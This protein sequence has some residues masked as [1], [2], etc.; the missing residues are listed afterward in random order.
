[1]K[2]KGYAWIYLAG[3]VFLA[4]LLSVVP[5]PPEVLA[6]P[7]RKLGAAQDSVVQPA[8]AFARSASQ[9]TNNGLPGKRISEKLRPAMV[10]L[11]VPG[12]SQGSGFVISKKH[13]LV[14]TAGHVADLFTKGLR[15]VAFREGSSSH[16]AVERVWYH[17]RIRRKFDDFLTV[18]SN[19]PND[20]EIVGGCFD[21]AVLQLSADGTILPAETQL[22]AATDAISFGAQPV[23]RL[24]YSGAK[25]RPLPTVGHSEVAD[26]TESITLP[27]INNAEFKSPELSFDS[28]LYVDSDDLPDDPAAARS[29]LRT[30]V[31]LEF[32]PAGNLTAGNTS[33]VARKSAF[34]MS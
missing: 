19:D 18:Q 11:T 27:P 34:S 21:L 4:I 30:V 5:V 12:V 15:L 31:S 22:A 26:F 25:P 32:F 20:G 23:G 10:F 24:S 13:R 33:K 3:L 8:S 9:P 16:Y 1:M 6:S 17:P 29:F 28:M 7:A 14:A 2:F